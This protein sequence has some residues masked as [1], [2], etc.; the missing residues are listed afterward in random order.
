MGVNAEL[1]AA[2]TTPHGR[3]GRIR[4]ATHGLGDENKKINK[5]IVF[6]AK[7]LQMLFSHLGVN[8]V[9]PCVRSPIASHLPV[10]N[11]AIESISRVW[12]KMKA[13]KGIGFYLLSIQN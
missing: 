11:E 7:L 13:V 8:R 2:N 5:I 9:Q 3:D 12:R 4:S 6:V 1:V 10:P